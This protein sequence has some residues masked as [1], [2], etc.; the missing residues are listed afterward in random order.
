MT[1]KHNFYIIAKVFKCTPDGRVAR[2]YY[3]NA[4]TKHIA[5]P[6]E[7]ETLQKARSTAKE[8]IEDIGH[9]WLE[10]TVCSEAEKM[11]DGGQPAFF[12]LKALVGIGRL[13][14]MTQ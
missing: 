12:D 6:I 4:K 9:D 3:G 14:E 10:F 7:A 13:K 8:I 5:T 1:H 2:D 11:W